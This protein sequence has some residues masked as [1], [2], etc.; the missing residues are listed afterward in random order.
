VLLAGLWFALLVS[1]LFLALWWVGEARK[2][3]VVLGWAVLLMVSI[4]W[5]NK[6]Q[7]MIRR[8]EAANPAPPS[9]E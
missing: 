4:L 5:F 6:R 2:L 1:M 8:Q 9:R 3:W 7:S